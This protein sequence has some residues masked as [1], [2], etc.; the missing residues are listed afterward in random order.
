MLVFYSCVGLTFFAAAASASFP[1]YA[2]V[3][4]GGKLR[5]GVVL[6]TGLMESMAKYGETIADLNDRRDICL[7]WVSDDEIW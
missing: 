6:L 1:K 3:G 4:D 5:P 7:G 2:S